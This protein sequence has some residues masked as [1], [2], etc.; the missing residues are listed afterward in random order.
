[1]RLLGI[2]LVVVGVLL[3]VYGGVTLFIPSGT[4]NAGPFTITVN[5]NLVIPLPPIVGLIC[6][7]LGAVMVMSAPTYYGP[8]PPY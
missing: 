5:E 2:I 4:T 3:L 7:I 8:P 1:M 6:L